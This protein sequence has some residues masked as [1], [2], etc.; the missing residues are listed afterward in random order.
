MFISITVRI[1][2]IPETKTSLSLSHACRKNSSYEIA[3]LA[4]LRRGSGPIYDATAVRSDVGLSPDLP[5]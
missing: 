5:S 2:R 3:T 1:E 4:S